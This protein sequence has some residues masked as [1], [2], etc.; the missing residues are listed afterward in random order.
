LRAD[1]RRFIDLAC[2]VEKKLVSSLNSI[3]VFPPEPLCLAFLL[4]GDPAMPHYLAIADVDLAC[5]RPD[6]RQCHLSIAPELVF[7]DGINV[8]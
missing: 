3:V 8:L 7:Y 5:A 2:P 6:V 4:M 1:R